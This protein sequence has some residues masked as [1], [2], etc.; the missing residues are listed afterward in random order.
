MAF[1]PPAPPKRQGKPN[2]SRWPTLLQRPKESRLLRNGRPYQLS[3]LRRVSVRLLLS[4]RLNHACWVKKISSLPALFAWFIAAR[5]SAKRRTVESRARNWRVFV[6]TRKY[7][8]ETNCRI[9]LVAKELR[10]RPII[11]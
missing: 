5:F 2:N 11:W 10:T 9:D 3:K 4:L 8:L 1:I 6:Y 7:G